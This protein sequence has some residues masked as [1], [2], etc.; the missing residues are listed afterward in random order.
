VTLDNVEVSTSAEIA[1]KHCVFG[2]LTE[3]LGIAEMGVW[4]NE[5]QLLLRDPHL[6]AAALA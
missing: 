1:K 3:L 6:F 4:D 5:T 2:H